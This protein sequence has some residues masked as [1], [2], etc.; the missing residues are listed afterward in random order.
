MSRPEL[1][2]SNQLCFLV[3]RLDREIA[4]RYRPLLTELGLTYPQYLAMLALWER[5]G[6]T[7]GE[8]CALLY[9]D[10]GTV[11]PLIKRLEAAGL[12]ERRR[13]PDDER[14]V[15]VRLSEAGRALE[16]KAEGVPGAMA[17]C[18]LSD[19]GDYVS[20]KATLS[21]LIARLESSACDAEPLQAQ[22]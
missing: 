2:L 9:L 12:V 1:L 10:T 15:V 18:L 13:S 5:D 14:T 3:H 16:R 20:L 11:S 19:P 8:L 4:A 22:M 21:G 17:G 6:Q 7:V